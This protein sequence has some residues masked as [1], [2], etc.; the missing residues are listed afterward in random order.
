MKHGATIVLVIFGLLVSLMAGCS[1]ENPERLFETAQFEEKQTNIAHAR[2]LYQ[3]I[4]LE[5]PG[6]EWESKAKARLEKTEAP[7]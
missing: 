6:S 7:Q 4:I 1:G 5:H 3:R 2:E